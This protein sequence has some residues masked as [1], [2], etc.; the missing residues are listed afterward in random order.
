[1][2]PSFYKYL[3]SNMSMPS[4]IAFLAGSPFDLEIGTT[5]MLLDVPPNAP[6]YLLTPI[7]LGAFY[8]PMTGREPFMEL[9][10]LAD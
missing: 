10:S 2:E 7:S 6:Y 5:L 4:L 3:A 1:M 8:F 9:F